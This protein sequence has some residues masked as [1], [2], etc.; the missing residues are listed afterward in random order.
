M[1]AVP[2]LLLCLL[3]F[4]A[5]RQVAGYAAEPRPDLGA[6]LVSDA[7]PDLAA[8]GVTDL[9]VDLSADQTTDRGELGADLP[10]DLADGGA[11]LEAD[12]QT[13]L[14]ADLGADLGPPSPHKLC[15]T[16]EWCWEN[17]VPLSA[18]LRG[19]WGKSATDVHV[20]GDNGV[21]LH[22]DGTR[23]LLQPDVAQGNNLLRVTGKGNE[24]YAVGADGTFLR[25]AAGSWQ[26]EK[27]AVLPTNKAI[28]A[29]MVDGSGAVLV[30]GQDGL[31]AQRDTNGSWSS[32]SNTSYA[33]SWFLS[34]RQRGGD[35][36]FGTTTGD[37]LAWD[38]SSWTPDSN[39]GAS[40]YGLH[41]SATETFAAT[42]TGLKTKQSAGGWTG[43]AGSPAPLFAL[44]GA[45][46][47]AFAVGSKSGGATGVA[48]RFDGTNWTP[49]ANT[50]TGL[51]DVWVGGSGAVLAVGD[52]GGA[53]SWTSANGW[54]ALTPSPRVNLC[55]G[56]TDG[57]NAWTGGGNDLLV[58]QNAGWNLEQKVPNTDVITA[59]TIF[60]GALWV[61]TAAG[62]IY[63][64]KGGTLTLEDTI[65][66]E[67]FALGADANDLYAA[68]D[69]KQVYR[70]VG[71]SFTAYA[72]A[73]G[74]LN[75]LVVLGSDDLLLA[76]S[77]GLERMAN[78]VPTTF[79]SPAC[80]RVAMDDSTH[81]LAVCAV[82]QLYRV[83]TVGSKP[84]SSVEI[85]DAK[86]YVQSVWSDGT[87]AWAT[88]TT[89]GLRRRVATG[90]WQDVPLRASAALRTIFGQSVKDLYVAGDHGTI[91]HRFVP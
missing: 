28:E 5:C 88:S 38:G 80:T 34:L 55:C 29:V 70:L 13:D 22:W 35:V 9:P 74:T 60:K 75:D 41:T 69:N 66:G 19:L 11:D 64:R 27:P 90:S 76:T 18:G 25:F 44:H 3:G 45:G 84:A 6:D 91:A 79:F 8:D 77:K 31:V 23:W 78:K 58:R 36:L 16:G 86:F 83:M 30:A 33:T 26:P 49:T 81:A 82:G 63:Q 10:G 57:T 59:M 17:P 62:R 42:F 85:A 46:N 21:L 67:V 15:P 24:A 72:Q 47:L 53:Y 4:S 50:A 61:G 2:L 40:T 68:G 14:G 7:R 52:R 73:N 37:V 51:Q 20:V 89:G 87:E 65:S 54:L 1:R 48:M 71:A 12:L 43:V 32:V 39:T 56:A